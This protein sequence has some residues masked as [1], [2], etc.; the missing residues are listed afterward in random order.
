MVVFV[1]GSCSFILFGLFGL[2]DVFGYVIVPP[3]PNPFGSLPFSAYFLFLLIL[4]QTLGQKARK[5]EL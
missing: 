1:V 3:A 2:F 4:S 5:E